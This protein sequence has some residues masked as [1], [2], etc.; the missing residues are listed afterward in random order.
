MSTLAIGYE[1]SPGAGATLWAYLL[2]VLKEAELSS[3]L[4]L[5]VRTG[6]VALAGVDHVSD[7][8]KELPHVFEDGRFAFALVA[9]ELLVW[10]HGT[11]RDRSLAG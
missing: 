6:H 3:V 8:M 2:D 7:V 9:G 4:E 5:A 10:I 1:D 11:G